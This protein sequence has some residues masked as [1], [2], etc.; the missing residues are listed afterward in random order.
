MACGTGAG[1]APLSA[2]LIPTP[3]IPVGPV[4]ADVP[5]P[6]ANLLRWLRLRWREP[7]RVW[8]FLPQMPPMAGAKSVPGSRREPGA[9][10][11]GVCLLA[12]VGFALAQ[13]RLSPAPPALGLSVS[14]GDRRDLLLAMKT[15]PFPCEPAVPSAPAAPRPK[16]AASGDGCGEP[17]LGVQERG[18][19]GTRGGLGRSL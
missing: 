16:D 5:E 3:G 7:P 4:G 18:D 17:Q 14:D 11:A 6:A 9:V 1:F 15:A 12:G 2:L 10:F 13:L 19:V 8:E